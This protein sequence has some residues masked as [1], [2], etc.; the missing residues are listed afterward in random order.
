MT[1]LGSSAYQASIIIKIRF[2]YFISLSV[3]LSLLIAFGVYTIV[4][5]ANQIEKE[6]EGLDLLQTEVDGLPQLT[7]YANHTQLG[8]IS[9]KSMSQN[10]NKPSLIEIDLGA[11]Y[12]IDQI[13]IIPAVANGQERS[14][15][16]PLLFPKKFEV[17]LSP[18]S[19][20]KDDLWVYSA[21]EPFANGEQA[22]PYKIDCNQQMARYVVIKILKV[23]QASDLNMHY[24]SLIS[25]VFVFSNGENVA[26]GREVKA[27]FYMKVTG[28]YDKDYVVD[29]L[30]E[31]GFPE[32]SSEEGIQR[33]WHSR[34]LRNPRRE[35]YLNMQLAEPKMLDT[36]ILYPARSNRFRQIQNYGF[37][38]Y[39]EIL[40]KL[41]NGKWETVVD[42]TKKPYLSPGYNPAA[43]TFKE[44]KVQEIRVRSDRI[45]FIH[46][47]YA[48][49]FSEIELLHNGKNFA[50]E[51]QLSS[52]SVH[53][54][55]IAWSL[56]SVNDGNSSAGRLIGWEK[57]LN[58]LSR[59]RI[60]LQEIDQIEA[61]L[62]LMNA[63][64]SM[65]QWL[66]LAILLLF[67]I[68]IIFMFSANILH[69]KRV[70]KREIIEV[71][72]RI[73]G[74]LHDEVGSN[75]GAIQLH[76]DLLQ[77]TYPK[78]KD[79]SLIQI[80][81][82][83]TLSA[84][85]DI[86]WILRPQRSERIFIA[87]HFQETSAIFLNGLAWDF[88]ADEATKYWEV[89][90]TVVHDLMLFYRE[91]L[92]NIRHANAQKVDIKI[93]KTNSLFTLRVQD[94]GCGIAPEKLDK[95]QT[96][97]ALKQRAN[98]MGASLQIYSELELGT[99]ITLSLPLE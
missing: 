76:L 70:R 59:R 13:F 83:Q 55:K 50:S 6:K 96:L 69:Q 22:F 72:E 78:S 27:S 19:D 57:W 98:K 77:A 20:F 95:T 38:E 94:D 45:P 66:L 49:A 34:V 40:A 67:G 84:V 53:G 10:L 97:N 79:F 35:V 63:K 93:T 80:L 86:V 74:D 60:A 43:F 9:Q 85:R 62:V 68:G 54:D 11:L 44:R 23:E 5:L 73:A 37:P 48:M 51:A 64:L 25:E 81:V 56:E 89:S 15:N 3:V 4:N 71:R 47:G 92:Y 46:L 88:D 82:A 17:L 52:N 32:I 1:R 65:R 18:F 42:H 26:L 99:R 39:F 75:I 24:R 12:P 33:G 31:F 7:V 91:V 14:S 16:S 58:Q 90:D 28:L 30:T 21:V 41:E 87:D 36:I 8:L 29:G 61:N 2:K